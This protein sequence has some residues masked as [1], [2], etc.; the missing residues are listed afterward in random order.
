MSMQQLPPRQKMIN[1]MYLVLT[2]ILALN[3]SG[4]VLEAFQRVNESLSQSE[5]LLGNRNNELYRQLQ[6]EY[7]RD[8]VKTKPAWIKA[9]QAAKLTQSFCSY[10]DSLKRELAENA[11]GI[12]PKTGYINR[13]DD[14]EASTRM[15]VES[16]TPKG[17]E[18]RGRMVA[19]RKNLLEIL[20]EADRQKLA[21]T[22]P[23]S[24]PQSK[25]WEMASFYQVPAVAASTNLTRIMH[26]ARSSENQVAE[27]ILN[28]IDKRLNKVDKMQAGI[29]SPSAYVLEG[30]TYSA[31]VLVSAYSSTQHP[32]VFLG[33]VNRSLFP[34]DG[35]PYHSDDEIP[36]VANPQ[37]VFTEN[38]KG[39]LKMGGGAGDH[40]YEGVIRVQNPV[41]GWD[42]Y[43]FAGNYRVG[44]KNV[45]VSPKKMNV[46]Y[47]GLD[48]P[49]DIS[50]PGVAA[51]DLRISTDNGTLVKQPDG[52]FTARVVIPGRAIVKVDAMVNGK[53]TAMGTQEFRVK[54]I[55]TPQSTV[56]GVSQGGPA[57]QQFITQR[58]S[59]VPKLD[60]FVYDVPFQVISF[61]CSIR[62]GSEISKAENYGPVFNEKVRNLVKTL[63]AGDAFFIDDIMVRFPN[64]EVRK[65]A[66]IAFQ[67]NR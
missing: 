16:N 32:E 23:L 20:D 25:D 14:L 4:E 12:D 46:L 52:T 62:K 51:A 67:V 65:I 19:Y 31:D 42:F 50:V 49:V 13:S 57:S 15:F 29:V 40:N 34:A 61:N 64:Q 30:E 55:P 47:I 48:N 41:S 9:Q 5:N 18:L 38:G 58:Q 39:K 45:V 6:A 10:V 36:P 35:S 1:M 21:K 22:L 2:A 59:I 56:D 28:S 26:E 66:P 60:D 11:G 17:E 7:E 63:K 27:I 3:V 43:P 24:E 33:K 53:L 8:S 54:K 44:K 37:P